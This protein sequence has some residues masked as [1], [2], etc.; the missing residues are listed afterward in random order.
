MSLKRINRLISFSKSLT[1]DF[2]KHIQS[3]NNVCL[4]KLG[5]H[6]IP[7]NV[8]FPSA[9]TL[10]L[11]NCN[12]DGILN[13][14]TPN[15]F[16]N[17][18]NVNYLSADPGDFKL[19]ERYNDKLKW[20]FPN[21]TYEFYDFMVKSGR[22]KKDPELIKNYLTNKRIIDGKNGFDISFEFDLNIPDYGI[23]NGEWWR[24]QFYEYLVKQQ[25]IN[26]YSD[27]VYPGEIPSISIKQEIEEAR[28]E[29]EI[30]AEKLY[31]SSFEDILEDD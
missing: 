20:V 11:I 19:Y 14:F 23:V 31:N 18:T 28:I 24:S 6:H 16:P 10:T 7:E 13:I 2:I 25:N 12:R 1:P 9:K 8:A 21:K 5:N 15:I 22:G 30:V 4:Y 17:L 27:C 29:K 26:K 3:T